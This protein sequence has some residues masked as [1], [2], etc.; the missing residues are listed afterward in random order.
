MKMLLTMISLLLAVHLSSGQDTLKDTLVVQNQNLS[1]AVISIEGMACQE[2]C[3]DK[4][5]SNLKDAE[6]VVST[7]VSYEK[8]E[9]IITFDTRTITPELL[10]SIITN[11]KVKEYV[12]TIKN[13]II[14]E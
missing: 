11:T 6:G 8:K 1:T 13:I 14:K 5:S 4:I 2:G 9:A 7:V 3:A 10:K 12:Y